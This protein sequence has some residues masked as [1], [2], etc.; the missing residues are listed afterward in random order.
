MSRYTESVSKKV[1]Y[2]VFGLALPKKDF[3]VHQLRFPF[4]S[5]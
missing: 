5:V 2:Q 3:I 4:I 1:A